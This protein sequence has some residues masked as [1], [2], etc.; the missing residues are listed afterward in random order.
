MTHSLLYIRKN[1]QGCEERKLTPFLH[2]IIVSFLYFLSPF[3]IL[4]NLKSKELIIVYHCHPSRPSRSK[5]GAQMTDLLRNMIESLVAKISWDIID[6]HNIGSIKL[7][8]YGLLKSQELD[9]Y[10]YLFN[11]KIIA[12]EQYIYF[13][14]LS[15]VFYPVQYPDIVKATQIESSLCEDR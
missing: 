13:A 4:V 14:D 9:C 8:V 15:P 1:I 2:H 5:S 3:Q 12:F 6:I 10:N 11:F 7:I